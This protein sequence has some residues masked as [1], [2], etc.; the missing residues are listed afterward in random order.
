MLTTAGGEGM[1]GR[2]CSQA[3]PFIKWVMGPRER[4][5]ADPREPAHPVPLGSLLFL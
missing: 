5:L 2:P 1:G 3:E 4:L